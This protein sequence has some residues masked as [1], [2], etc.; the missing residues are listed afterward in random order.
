[1][2][3]LVFFL[4]VSSIL[5]SNSLE[6]AEVKKDRI[7]AVTSD[8]KVVSF[9]AYRKAVIDYRSSNPAFTGQLSLVDLAPYFPL[10]YQETPG[11]NN[12]INTNNIFVYTQET[13]NIDILRNRLMNSMLV[14]HND[15]GG[16]ITLSGSQTNIALP[17]IIPNGSIVIVGS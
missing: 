1:M 15:A 13:M 5:L 17:P 9:L 7:Q 3:V 14:G 8:V 11:W 10:G 4:M 12:V 16:L 2:Y 6:L